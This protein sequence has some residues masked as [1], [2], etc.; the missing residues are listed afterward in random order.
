MIHLPFKCFFTLSVQLSS[1]W[2]PF[3]VGT[4]VSKTELAALHC[5]FTMVSITLLHLLCHQFEKPAW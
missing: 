2:F 1:I 4:P 3:I 5:C